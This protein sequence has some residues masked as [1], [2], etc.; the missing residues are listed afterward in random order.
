MFSLIDV[1]ETPRLPH[2]SQPFCIRQRGERHRRYSCSIESGSKSREAG[3]LT[4]QFCDAS[5]FTAHMMPSGMSLARAGGVGDRPTI[6]KPPPH[7]T[8]TTHL[9]FIPPQAYCEVITTTEMFG[10]VQ[11]STPVNRGMRWKQSLKNSF[12][13]KTGEGRKK[14]TEGR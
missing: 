3:S 13:G 2:H 6:S 1:N 7:P 9:L 10:P 11:F 4:H 12:Q 14:S 8:I 5:V